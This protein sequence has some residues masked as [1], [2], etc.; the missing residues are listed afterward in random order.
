MFSF[1]GRALPDSIFVFAQ[2]GNVGAA[3]F[4]NARFRL[5]LGK[6]IRAGGGRSRIVRVGACDCGVLAF[7]FAEGAAVCANA[8]PAKAALARAAMAAVVAK[9]RFMIH[10]PFASLHTHDKRSADR[11]RGHRALPGTCGLF[12]AVKIV[13]R[14]ETLACRFFGLT[15]PMR[16]S[17]P[18]SSRLQREPE[19][20]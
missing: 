12:A 7:G 4:L 18:V 15:A 10:F 5:G 16:L 14:M 20:R 19:P 17:G 11:K 9:N 13:S 1:G 6:A 2:T 8:P 3:G